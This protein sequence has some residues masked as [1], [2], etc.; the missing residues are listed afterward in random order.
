MQIQNRKVNVF[1]NI[2]IGITVLLLAYPFLGS[3]GKWPWQRRIGRD[4][5]VRHRLA[6]QTMAPD[7]WP[8]EPPSP[9]N[10]DSDN[11]KRALTAAREGKAV[12]LPNDTARCLPRKVHRNLVYLDVA[13]VLDAWNSWELTELIDGLAP[14][15]RAEVPA[16]T[17]AGA[18]GVL[19]WN[20]LLKSPMGVEGLVIG[21][22]CNFIA[23]V[24][25][26]QLSTDG[27]KL[28]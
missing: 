26:K 17:V 18:S 23:F 9:E 27:A 8:A 10:V 24:V 15:T 6:Y 5:E 28:K 3:S 11:L 19:I 25:T 16:G 4:V 1:N 2:P 21:V 12:V 20:R 22:F 7:V 13:V 14:S